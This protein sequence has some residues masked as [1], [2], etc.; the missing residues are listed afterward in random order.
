MKIVFERV[1]DVLD[2]YKSSVYEQDA[3]KFAAAYA[4]DIHVFDC[5]QNWSSDGI[6]D[7]STM[8]TEWF[9]GLKQEG[10]RLHVAF[11]DVATEESDKLAF[12]RCAVTFKACD[13]AGEVVRQI[14]NRFTFGLRKEHGS[15]LIAHE[16]SS[17]PIDMGTGKGI[18]N[19]K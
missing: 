17:L 12:V 5:W 1:Q 2:N 3:A 14:T 7:W 15:W 19:L 18:F 10:V 4:A 6:A 8:A 9:H 11:D 13:E 16:H